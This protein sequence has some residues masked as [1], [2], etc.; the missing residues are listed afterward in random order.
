MQ[1]NSFFLFFLVFA[2]SALEMKGVKS[3]R[4]GDPQQSKWGRG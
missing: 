1:F 2:P 3:R 4:K